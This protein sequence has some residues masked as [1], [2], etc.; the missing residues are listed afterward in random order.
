MLPGSMKVQRSSCQL[1][2]NI[3]KNSNIVLNIVHLNLQEN[4]QALKP[5]SSWS[6]NEFVEGEGYN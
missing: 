3:S 1:E 6:K 4:Q 5:A 2:L